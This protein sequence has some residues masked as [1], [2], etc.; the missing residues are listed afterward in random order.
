M[1]A[2]AERKVAALQH[3]FVDSIQTSLR[4]AVIDSPSGFFGLLRY[5]LAWEDAAGQPL[6]GDGGK[7]LRPVL[8]L[9]AC[10]LCGADW[11]RAL[12]AAAALELVHN[13]SLIHDDIQDGDEVRRGR[14]T[15]WSVRGVAPAITAGNAML[16]I[17]D[18]A[19]ASLT[20]SGVPGETVLEAAA[21][22]TAHYL[23][24]IEG[25]YLDMAF[26]ER[27]HVTVE[28]YLDMIGRKTGALIESAM[29][30]GALIAT[31]RRETANT[32]GE[33]G[34]KLGLAF[35]IR[36]DFL[37]VWGHPDQ[38]GKPVAADIR[39]KKKTLPMVYMFQQAAEDDRAWLRDAYAGE[40]VS[41]TNVE[42]ILSLLERLGAQ[43]YV[44]GIAEGQAS[45]ALTS[46]AA[47]NLPEDAGGKL[48]AMA[49]Y[50]VTR[51]K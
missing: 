33:C 36:D 42:R 45:D 41:G 44:Q 20:K 23:E 15:L 16:V 8:C 47:L 24:M 48:E 11:H 14:P 7:G 12:P 2:P 51:Q 1:L 32:F 39:R 43:S 46:V 3:R 13:F 40:E 6:A 10:D 25:Q 22:L 18:Q 21:E 37:G 9:T 30:L 28:E 4:E 27:E 17:A 31:G 35:Q 5:H 50:F 29:Y 49:E 19:L 38:T 34:R 26:E